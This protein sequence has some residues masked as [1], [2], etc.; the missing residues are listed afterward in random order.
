MLSSFTIA[1]ADA[2]YERNRHLLVQAET[3]T[4]LPMLDWPLKLTAYHGLKPRSIL[5]VG[6]ANGWRL[7]HFFMRHAINDSY[8]PRCEGVDLSPRAIAEGE[9]LFPQISLWQG[10]ALE[11]LVWR[12]RGYTRYD[13][14]IAGFFLYLVDRAELMMMLAAMDEA[15]K[16]GGHL[17]IYDF[18]PRLPHRVPY[19]HRQG[20]Y[21]YKQDYSQPFLAS[22]LYEEVDRVIFDHETHEECDAPDDRR[23]GVVLLRKE[24]GYANQT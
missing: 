6:A 15:L 9:A 13:L 8:E 22:G 10:D 20:L 21:S 19:H 3:P 17:L 1:D 14:V 4:A 18:L 2:W 16:P 23:A 12:C 24:E 5:E 7:W 11:M